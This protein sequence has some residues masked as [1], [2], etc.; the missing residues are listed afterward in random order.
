MDHGRGGE[1]TVSS[2]G[3]EST[4]IIGSDG[5]R[6]SQSAGRGGVM[7]AKRHPRRGR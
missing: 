6:S 7:D 4:R 1:V 2:G 3:G 5:T